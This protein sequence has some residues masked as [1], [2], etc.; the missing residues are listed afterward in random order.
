MASWTTPITSRDASYVAYNYTDLSRVEENTQYLSDL[1]NTEG[2]L[3]VVTTKYPWTLTGYSSNYFNQDDDTRYLTN[4][5]LLV[6]LLVMPTT[7]PSL[8]ANLNNLTRKI[9]DNI[10]QVQADIK[11]TIERIQNN[12]LYASISAGTNRTRQFIQRG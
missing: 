4:I 9:A 12:K 8:P 7:T 5:Q 1:L 10:E 11:D 3:N 6:D 2:Y